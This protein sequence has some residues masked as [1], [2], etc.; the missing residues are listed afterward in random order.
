MSDT[1]NAA[2]GE[3]AIFFMS[4]LH[5]RVLPASAPA[6]YPHYRFEAKL[7]APSR[8]YQTRREGLQVDRPAPAG[9][10]TK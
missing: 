10:N 6:Q 4:F 8:G 7:N 2:K 9:I 3:E 5:K 1:N